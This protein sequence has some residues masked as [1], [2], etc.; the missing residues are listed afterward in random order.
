MAYIFVRFNAAQLSVA[1]LNTYIQNST[2]PHEG[3]AQIEDLVCA[4]EGGCLPCEVD[5]YVSNTDESL[6]AQD[7]G[8]S[9]QYNLR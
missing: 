9:A 8:L 5:V 3:M 1:Q 7:G 2:N 4:I 6:S